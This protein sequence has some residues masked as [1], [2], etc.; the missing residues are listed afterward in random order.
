M[1]VSKKEI[2]TELQKLAE[3]YKQAGFG[4]LAARLTSSAA[5]FKTAEEAPVVEAPKEEPAK[6]EKVKVQA[7]SDP[8]FD[9]E[10]EGGEVDEEEEEEDAAEDEVEDDVG[11]EE[12]E[13]DAESDEDVDAEDEAADEE[14]EEGDEATEEDADVE[15][16][17]DIALRD[18]CTK[19]YRAAKRVSK[20]PSAK[21]RSLATR[22]FKVERLIRS[23]L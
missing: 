21:V 4:K 18:A 23:T 8:L 9:E 7:E 22:L 10:D 12:E 3:G 15:M 16:D 1:S 5:L 20:H 17:E 6:E 11:G 2:E 19:L 14:D 13:E